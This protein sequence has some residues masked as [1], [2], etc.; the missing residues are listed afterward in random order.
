MT[1]TDGRVY[2]FSA[3]PAVL[4]EEVLK[5]GSRRDDELSKFRYVRNGDVSQV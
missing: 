2:N 5:T 1:Q 3:G 4:P